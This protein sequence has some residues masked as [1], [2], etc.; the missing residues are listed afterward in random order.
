MRSSTFGKGLWV[1]FFSVV[2]VFVARDGTAHAYI[3]QVDGT[4]VPESGRMQ[5]CL[6]RAGTGETMAGALNAVE[7]AQVLPEAYRPVPNASG[8]YD[9]TF[10]DIGEGAGFRNSFGWFWL[11]DDVTNPANLRTIFGCRTYDTCDCPC[12]T[13]RTITVDFDTQ[14]GFAAGRPIG[15][16]LR[17]PERLDNSRENGTFDGSAC[18]FNR[19]CDPTGANV[20]DSCG[21]RLDTNNRIYFTNAALNDDGDFKHFLVY[22]SATRPNTFYF[23]FEDLFRGGDNDFEDMLVRATG[24]VPLCDPR[25]ETC[26]NLDDDCDGVIDDGLTQACGTAC[27]AGVRTCVAGSFGAC[28]APTP[29]TENGVVTRC[30]N[31]D[32]DCDGTIDE[33][34]SRA[35]SNECG[36]GTEVCIAGTFAG[37]NARRPTAELCNG[38]DD[39]CDGTTDEGLTRACSSSCGS[40]IETCSM[41]SF[42]G[43]TAPTPSA[44]TC[45]NLDNDCDGRTD[46]GPITMACSTACGGG[47]ATCISGVFV[48]C[49]AATPR[50]ETCDG[51]D[52]DCDGRIDEGLTRTCSSACGL[53]TETCAAGAWAGCDAPTPGVE[54]CNNLDDDC[55]GIIDDGN[56]GGGAECVPDGM[57]GYV[58]DPPDGAA[59]IPGRVTCVAGDLQCLG[60]TSPS[61]EVCNCEDDDCDGAIDEEADGSLCGTGACI[62]CRCLTPCVDGEFPCPPGRVCNEELAP[63]DGGVIGYC[64]GGMCEGVV[65]DEDSVCEP[66]TGE[67]RNLC[68]GVSCRPG[69][70]CV[71][72]R[73][74]EDNCYGRGCPMG[75]R[76]RE[77]ACEPDPCAGV[78]CPEGQY[79]DEG[80]CV[81]PCDLSCPSGQRCEDGACVEA[82]CGGT[83]SGDRRCVDGACVAPTCEPACG[84]AR[85][86]VG[87]TCFDDPC[88]GRRCPEGSICRADDGAC[89]PESPT[90]PPERVLG[91]AAGGGGCTCDAA[92]APTPGSDTAGAGIA[93]VLL[94]LLG[95][96]RRASRVRTSVSRASLR[97]AA[98]LTATSALTLTSAGCDVEPFCFENCGEL[99][100]DSGPRDAGV[101]ARPAD[102]CIPFG[103]EVCNER[104]DDCDGRVDETFDLATDPRNCGACEAECVLPGA[105]PGC[106]EGECTIDECEI[107]FHDLDGNPTNGCEYEC[108]PS[109]PELCDTRDNDC[110]GA[111][112]EGFDLTTD[113]ANCG[114][115]GNACVF[116]N[117]DGVCEAS[118]CRLDGCNEGFVDLDRDPSNGCEYRCAGSSGATELCNGADDDCDGNLDEGFDLASSPANCGACGRACAFT[119]ANP[120]CTMGVCGIASCRAGFVD[121]DGN[122]ATG[123]EYVCTPSGGVDDCDG[124]DDDCDGR[125]DEADA[126]VGTACGSS[127][128]ICR[129]GVNS[130]QRGAIVCV[131]GVAALP[132]ETCDGTDE[133]CDGRTD[134]GPG[135]PGVGDRCGGTNVGRCEYGT[136][137]CSGAALTCGGAFVGP[138]TETCNGLDDNCNGAIDDGL[139]T[140]STGSVASCANQTGV[141]AGRVPTCRGAGG[142]ACDFPSTYQATEFRCDTLDNDCDGTPDE[143]CLSARGTDRRL[144]THV[145]QSSLNS[146]APVIATG[147]GNLV[148]AAWMETSRSGDP[149]RS[150]P[151]VYFA[152]SNDGGATWGTPI[153]LDSSGGPAFSPQL[154]PSA[155]Q[156]VAAVWADFRGGTNYRE[157]YRN[158]ST[159]GGASFSGNTKVNA[160]GETATADSFGVDLA[161]SGNNVYVVFEAFE[162]TRRRQVY[163]SRSTNNGN[164]WTEPVQ[165]SPDS[166]SADYVAA[167]PRVAASGTRVHVVWRDNR[168]GGADLYVRTSRNSGSAFDAAVRVDTGDLAGRNESVDPDIAADG[169]NAYV[170]WVDNRDAGSLDIWM[171]RSI[172][173][174][175]SWLATATKLD[176]DPFPHDSI[177]PRVVALSSSRAIVAWVDYRDGFPDILTSRSTNAGM[178]FSAPVRLDTGTAAGTS[179]SLA[180]SLAASGD[181]VA[182][183]WSDDRSGFTDVYANF[184]LDAGATWQPQDYRMDTNTIGTTDSQTPSVAVGSSRVH[185]VWTDHR[186]GSGCPVAGT[187]CPNA[188]IY[189]R[190]ME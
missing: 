133:D 164:T 149:I 29:V 93:L 140:P 82:P 91:L 74:V 101:D 83:C 75:E 14:P 86:C 9:V 125:I 56:P 159:D 181:L 89:V 110:D 104:D 154:A 120:S 103:D 65:C 81:A 12:A 136:F 186:R 108:P 78:G 116:A 97:R 185:V 98:L 117:G 123:C 128:G 90:M 18:D 180:V 4:V 10:V 189:Y 87:D 61:R 127:T 143:G 138:I 155:T 51:S 2:A 1:P 122:P 50:L 64:V 132:S 106:A 73:C 31:L 178:T 182:A 48:G 69:D 179:A 175:A 148:Y 19:G 173:A 187:Q 100:P 131:G 113:R 6:D 66:A 114:T 15:F 163:F 7:D 171:N 142:F 17:T 35:C 88:A 68:D 124:I 23:G 109:G 151:H 174:G 46:E 92:G 162:T 33:G 58:L 102:G 25:P 32:N 166:A 144:D 130:C 37:C 79:C 85:V 13:T 22:E 84:R 71:R 11:G 41:G 188:D 121:L 16:W 176:Q 129:P 21:G 42:R 27:G 63:P 95:W 94:G 190:R 62:E 60:A 43:C 80:T 165:L 150:F 107:G 49:T 30:D 157:I 55:N 76:C 161:V 44:E 54:T 36:A 40:G 112:D 141:C 47:I 77:A 169:D 146:L 53:G 167:T 28:S 96:R 52:E 115:C 126:R 3:S 67:C 152:R 99:V 5:A 20:N 38:T 170:V 72:G 45:D 184:S 59:C 39:D 135:V 111:V 24:L 137:A 158:R 134:E 26:N 160:T 177:A 139:T 105:F 34:I 147:S 168:N 183:A 153:L 8:S 118:T 145:T 70:A 156:D 172:D 57:G 119:N